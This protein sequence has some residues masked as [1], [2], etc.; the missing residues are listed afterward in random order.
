MMKYILAVIRLAIFPVISFGLY[1]AWLAGSFFIPNKLYWRQLIFR[2]W[3]RA[4]AR[5]MGMKI[6]VVGTPPKP[7]FFL[8]ANHLSYTDIPLL[9]A[10]AEGVFVAKGE[11]EGW[12]L[13]G[14]IVGDMGN[15][16]VNRQNRRDIPRAGR[17]ILER[18]NDG[19]GV[20]VFPEGTSTKGEEILKFNSSFLEFAAEID[21]PVHY[22]AIT[23]RTPDNNPP[24]NTISWWEP[25]DTLVGHLWRVFQIP[26]FTAVVTFGDEPVQ[27]ANRK[28][29][30]RRLWEKVNERFIPVL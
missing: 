5:L 27:D 6:E 4:F 20:I 7:P 10:V 8:V 23:Y 12:P 11:I 26:E 24:A 30:A 21:L 15:V 29:L 22:A 14:K 19:E 9:R 3:S 16:F 18:L 2:L 25:S 13:A 1:G 17:K 28:E